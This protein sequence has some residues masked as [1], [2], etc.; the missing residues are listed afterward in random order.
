MDDLHNQ[1]LGAGVE[2]ILLKR[3]DVELV[4]AML[5]RLRSPA[6]FVREVACPGRKGGRTVTDD[7]LA[8]LADPSP[9]VRRAAGFALAEVKGPA[10]VPR[11]LQRYNSSA[12][13]DINV[14]WAME[15]ALD[16]MCAC[17]RSMNRKLC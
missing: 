10:S 4:L 6:Y 2:R 9:M 16:E 8:A 7:L 13:E 15:C 12:T 14:R 11:L 17:I 1:G 3:D 5:H